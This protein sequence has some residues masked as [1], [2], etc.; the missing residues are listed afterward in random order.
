V[1]PAAVWIVLALCLAGSATYSGTET[2]MYGL[3]RVRVDLEARHGRRFARATRWLLRD[4][5]A[6]L[7]TILIGNN[8]AIELA[9]HF[10]QELLPAARHGTSIG[11]VYVTLLLAPVLFLFGEALP[12][13]LFRRRPHA[14]LAPVVPFILA[15]RIAYWPLERVVSALT[16][17][18][19][20]AFGLPGTKPAL[21]RGRELVSG[22]LA[23]GRRT[24]ALSH[25][26]EVLAQNA[27]TMRSTPIGRAMVP[28]SQVLR[29]DAGA[30]QAAQFDVVRG[31]RYSRLPVVDAAGDVLGYVHQLDVLAAGP[32]TPVLQH[33]LDLPRLAPDTAVDRALLALR[34]KGRRAAIVGLPGAPPLGIVTL[35]DL[36]EEISGELVGI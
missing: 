28:W 24:G 22:F 35:K 5:G 4:E 15:S 11:A 8:L 14:R 21:S 33:L 2:G 12:K 19:G 27:L 18:V 31:S 36:V 13:E 7:V 20:R 6:L 25:R 34:G 30:D 23:E 29:L 9:T 10:G 16:W 1:S 32:E 26:A 17:A 3:S